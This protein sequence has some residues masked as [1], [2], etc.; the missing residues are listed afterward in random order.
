M[1]KTTRNAPLYL[2]L[3]LAMLLTGCKSNDAQAQL[4]Q[5]SPSSTN[6]PAATATPPP[7]EVT[8]AALISAPTNTPTVAPSATATSA[9]P[10]VTPQPTKTPP[11]LHPL[12]IAWLRQQDFPGSDLIIEETLEPGSN[13]ERYI[14]SYLSEG[15]KIKA[16]LTMPTGDK[17]TPGWPVIIFNHGYIPPNQYR[18]TERY[19]AYVD[20]LAR[21]GYIVF[22]SDYR[23]H[24]DS[25]GEA[26]G[27][28]GSPDY[29]IDVLNAV[30]SLKK[31]PEADPNRIGMWGHSMGG[32]ITLR[33]MV[34]SQD[35]KAGVIWAGVVGSYP[36]LL[37]QWRLPN[38]QHPERPANSGH[39]WREN[40]VAD[41]GLP[42]ENPD[43]WAA[44]S[45]NSYVIDISGPVQLHHSP[46][47]S[48]VPSDFSEALHTQLQ[49]AGQTSEH[50]IYENDDHNI[51]ANF[52]LAME[53]SIAFF[54]Q[55][56]KGE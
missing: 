25:E 37:T 20:S 23:G 49:Q 33:A 38:H 11:P 52:G 54:D 3:I 2:M 34:T 1:T 51:S 31:H 13:Y 29:A 30:A 50:Y 40:L 27:G 28:Y 24:G 6:T 47:D 43:F 8:V 39:N 48:H 42:E 55:Y 22:K 36:D 17:P 53:R 35:I 32:Q 9:P 26:P 10:T 19:V 41:Y 12:T 5:S 44:I 15:L 45:P 4:T 18:T 7:T 56:V 21:S 14:A 46:T 16:L